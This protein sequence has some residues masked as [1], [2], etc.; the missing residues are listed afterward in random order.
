MAWNIEAD[1]IKIRDID[2]AKLNDYV[3]I[4]SGIRE[5]LK[6]GEQDTKLFIVG[7]KGLGKTL[8]LKVK[9]QLYRDKQPGYHCIP[10]E[11]LCEKFTNIGTSFSQKDLETFGNREIWTKT[12]EICLLTLILRSVGSELP[13][14]IRNLVADAQ[15]LPDILGALLAHRGEIP[16]LHAYVHTHLR[17]RVR[18]LRKLSKANQVAVF[19]DNIDEGLEEHTGYSLASPESGSSALSEDVWINAQLGILRAAKD[20]CVSNKH[21]KIFVAIRSEAYNLNRD[22]TSLQLDA[23]TTRL[24]YTKREIEDIFLQN[25]AATPKDQ[26][27]RPGADDPAARFLG[28]GSIP[29]RFVKMSDGE[30]RLEKAFDFIYRHTFGRPREIVQMGAQIRDRLPR[31]RREPQRVVDV[32]NDTA[33]SLFSQYKKEIIPYFRDDLFDFLVEHVN[34]NAF[35]FKEAYKTYK[36]AIEKLNFQDILSHF[37]RLGLIGIVENDRRQDFDRVRFVQKFLPV[38]Q[39]TLLDGKIPE[40]PDFFLVHPA[41]DRAFSAKHDTAYWG[42]DNII[43]DRYDFVHP[44]PKKEVSRHLHMGLDRDALSLVLPTLAEEKS[45]AVVQPPSKRWLPVAER[46]DM[47]IRVTSGEEVNLKV[48]SDRSSSAEVERWLREWGDGRHLLILTEK[49]DVM[50]RALRQAATLTVIDSENPFFLDALGRLDGEQSFLRSVFLC[51]RYPRR[52][53]LERVKSSISGRGSSTVW[54]DSMLID[55]FTYSVEMEGEEG[56][57][58][59]VAVAAEDCGSITFLDRFGGTLASSAIVRRTNSRRE[60]EFYGRKQKLLLE[61]VYRLCKIVRFGTLSKDQRTRDL[62]V[63]LEIFYAIQVERLLRSVKPGHWGSIFSTR[64]ESEVRSELIAYCREVYDRVTAI[65]KGYHRPLTS[66]LATFSRGEGVFPRGKEFYGLS[67]ASEGFVKSASVLLLREL[68]QIPDRK[69]IRSVFI[70]YTFRDGNMARK[71]NECLRKRGTP[72]FLFEKDDPYGSLKRIMA[73]EID[74][75]DRVIFLASEHSILSPACQFELS[76]CRRKNARHWEEMLV[77]IRLDDAVLRV[78][79]HELPREHREEFWENICMLREQH[80]KNFSQ[81]EYVAAERDL[82]VAVDKLVEEC[83]VAAR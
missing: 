11:E 60:Q 14:A 30:P 9:S 19:I 61:G 62:P 54:V 77:G 43:G 76:R 51:E 31:D 12:W 65:P 34:T 32:V 17:P 35:A 24:N 79:K 75:R 37:Y 66:R 18:D 10:R 44:A 71:L 70:S 2:T 6:C 29:H 83:L 25:I 16:K 7:P 49:P 63:A 26:L 72:T 82:E 52:R 80:M 55:R 78:E 64:A 33:D 28:F 45:L 74:R 59:S 42:K 23:Y 50:D 8:L 48:I 58:V 39:Y 3:V 1:L 57:E 15:Q 40:H 21:I 38:A 46:Q 47:R 67:R 5:F 73:E 22:T 27:A 53:A 81:Y 41:L 4:N 13:S 69:G 20:I 68:L 36:A 56:G